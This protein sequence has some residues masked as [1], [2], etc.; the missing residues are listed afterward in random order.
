MKHNVIRLVDGTTDLGSRAGLEGGE[1]VRP[2]AKRWV[3]NELQSFMQ[4][5]WWLE[6]SL[7]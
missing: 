1:F 2:K 7:S 4:K 3:K 6:T 5:C